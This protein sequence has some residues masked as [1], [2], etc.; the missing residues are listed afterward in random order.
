MDK[1]EGVR[2]NTPTRE[3]QLYSK[4]NF[5]REISLKLNQYAIDLQNELQAHNALKKKLKELEL[6]Y[7]NGFP[8]CPAC[9]ELAIVADGKGHKEDCWLAEAIKGVE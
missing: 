4:L 3:E 9:D 2:V 6:V 8:C 1:G 5:E 7:D